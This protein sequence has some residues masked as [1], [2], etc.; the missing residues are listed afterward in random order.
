MKPKI[1]LLND[2]GISAPGLRHLFES[3]REFADVYVVAPVIEKSGAGL[4]MTLKKPLIIQKVE[5]EGHPNAYSITGTPADCVKLAMNTILETPPDLII[6]GIN[7]GSNAG[8]NVLYSGTIGG[9]IEGVYRN[10]I[11]G[12][13]FSAHDYEEPN[14]EAFG[15]YILP[16]IQYFM[17]HPPSS[18]TLI[19]VNFPSLGTDGVKG[20]KMAR[21]GRG[22]WTDNPDMRKHP[23]GE[24]YFWLGGKWRHF[25]E[26][27][28]SDVHLLNQGY[29]T[30][31][32]IHVDELTDHNHLEQHRDAFEE[33]FR[34]LE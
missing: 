22:F 19:N 18:G 34:V 4:S 12:I 3:V 32:P 20:I 21:Q 14:F 5:W 26:Y 11:P 25:D 17:E 13:A 33:R 9:V 8:R 27:P 30:V 29:V 16:I 2:D 10:G 31:V 23:A 24:H 1:L 7:R 15:K 28:D 6:S